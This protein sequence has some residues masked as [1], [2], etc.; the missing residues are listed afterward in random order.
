VSHATAS[1]GSRPRQNGA[2]PVAPCVHEAPARPPDDPTRPDFEGVIA[3]AIDDWHAAREEHGRLAGRR[4]STIDNPRYTAFLSRFGRQEDRLALLLHAFERWTEER[5]D[6][7]D[8]CRRGAVIYRG[9]LFL[10][11]EDA[12]GSEP[13]CVWT[14]DLAKVPVL[15]SVSAPN[16]GPDERVALRTKGGDA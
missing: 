6:D 11:S 2:A 4:D 9:T 10:T 12:T 1:N 8:G 16:D 3:E 13:G 14:I 5:S 15:S 7:H